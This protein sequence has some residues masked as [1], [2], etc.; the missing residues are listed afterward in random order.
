MV[1][2]VITAC[3]ILAI[4]GVALFLY[5]RS[6]SVKP[7]SS[8]AKSVSS[9]GSSEPLRMRKGESM[10]ASAGAHQS[11]NSPLK[12][13][14][15]PR[16]AALG[17]LIA[18][19]F[20]S[21]SAKLWSMQILASDEYRTKSD[22][23]QLTTIKTPAARGRIYD[24]EGIVLVDNK[25]TPTIVA[26]AEVAQDRSVLMR[27]SA[28]T[29]V[30]YAVVRQRIQ[31]SSGGA[32]AQREV[33]SD[34]KARDVAFIAEHPEAFPG[35]SVQQRSK[36]V[37]PY[38]GLAG[39]VLGYTGTVTDDQL[40]SVPAGR[41]YQSGDEVGQSGVELTY[42]GYLF[43]SHGAKVVVS[44]VDGTV[45]EV[46]SETPPA[47]GSD[48]HL[49]ISAKVQ[50]I[51]E[52]ELEALIAPHGVIG[53]GTGTSGA[54]VAMEVDTGDVIAMAS[55][56]PFD[57][58]HFVGG[59]SQ[60]DW[61][62]YNDK[63]SSGSPLLNR[64]I[65]GQYPAAST[66]KAFT[67]MAGLH[68]GF[69]DSSRSWTC[70]GTW[71]GFGDA[72]PQKCWKLDGH[73][74][75]T[76]R[77]AMVV[78]CDT[79]FYEI[80]KSFYDASSTLGM[81]AMAD[82]VK[83]FGFGKKTGIELAGEGEGVVPTPEWKAKNWENAP[84]QGQWQPGDMSNMV[85]GQGNVIVTPLQMAVGYA[86]VATGKLPKPNLLKEVRNSSGEK[87]VGHTPEFTGEPEVSTAE[88][89]VVRDALR[90]VAE[91]DASIPALLEQY[92]YECA[93]KTGTG[94]W[95]EHDG[96]AWFAMYAPYDK[97]KYVVT[98]VITEGGS[99]AV[100]A[101]PIAAKVMDGCVKLGQ[102]ALEKE[103]TPT[104]EITQSVTYHGTGAGR[105]D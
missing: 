38:K 23:N 82:Y 88:L 95:A 19:I 2:A 99:G 91:E 100:T 96:Y 32:Q 12:D 47:Q 84:E 36:R 60:D 54:V 75:I 18:G 58:T 11:S 20:G 101:A 92:D 86:G 65:A 34:A 15:R 4:S 97:P 73:G 98:C 87:V 55:F 64:C 43:G 79:V 70:T 25:V 76:F 3:V 13:R 7:G 68:Y 59:V 48:L 69:A 27:L 49:T 51:A 8:V 10:A 105:V 66:F 39:Q 37:Y 26:D 104:E 67:G 57:P 93:C 78:S 89:D 94:E 44:D 21:L 16:Y 83:E 50:K 81:D 17:V 1:T 102:G 52:E 63:D 56:P 6:R 22:E 46:R 80:A 71:T 14:L 61:D 53:G 9:I 77:Q 62:R 72:Y 24:T 85:I 103:L 42:D 33:S 30:P 90:G 74:P 29:G 45:H 40:G 41:D 5:Y 28:L 31:D 35:V